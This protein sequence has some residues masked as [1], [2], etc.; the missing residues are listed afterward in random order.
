MFPN[1]IINLL[2]FLKLRLERCTS[3]CQFCG[4]KLLED[5]FRLSSC[6]SEFCV[7]KY[8]EIF[9]VNL[10]NE[11]QNNFDLTELNLSLTASALYSNR[12]QN[13][14]E[15]FPSFMLKKTEYRDRSIFKGNQKITTVDDKNK[16]IDHAR[17]LMGVLPNLKRLA[18][19]KSEVKF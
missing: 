16:N 3:Y 8:E 14:L 6:E 4:K 7:F 13:V 9:G 10:Y 5:S 19:L 1:M 15:P 11:L 17:K 2:A 18:D 12:V